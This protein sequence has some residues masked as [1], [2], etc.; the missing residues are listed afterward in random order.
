MG[1]SVTCAAKMSFKLE[2]CLTLDNV[3]IG[4]RLEQ[5]L[6]GTSLF[7]I[8]IMQSELYSKKF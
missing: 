3:V 7:N 4:Q 6:H 2:A 8:S 5:I 1:D